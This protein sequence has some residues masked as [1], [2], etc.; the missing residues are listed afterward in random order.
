M[1][2]SRCKDAYK[3]GMYENMNESNGTFS[4]GLLLIRL[5]RQTNKHL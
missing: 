1:K 4:H 5:L 3:S 2:F